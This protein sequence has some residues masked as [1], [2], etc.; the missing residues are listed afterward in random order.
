MICASIEREKNFLSRQFLL[1]IPSCSNSRGRSDRSGARSVLHPATGEM[2][3]QTD[4]FGKMEHEHGRAAGEF[5]CNPDIV[6]T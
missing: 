1:L 3:D 5:Y 6:W 4:K 2:R